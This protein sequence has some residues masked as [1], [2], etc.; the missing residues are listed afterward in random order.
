MTITRSDALGAVDNELSQVSD[1]IARCKRQIARSGELAVWGNT[2]LGEYLRRLVERHDQLE[3]AR[4][5]I[6][7]GRR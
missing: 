2:T 6:L 7:A 3:S 5:D 1:D 4:L